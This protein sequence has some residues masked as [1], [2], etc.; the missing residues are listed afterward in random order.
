VKAIATHVIDTNATDAV[1]RFIAADF[2]STQ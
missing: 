2:T 1:A